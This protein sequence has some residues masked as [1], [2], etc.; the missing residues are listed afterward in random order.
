M[1]VAVRFWDHAEQS[2]SPLAFVVYGEVGEVTPEHV[3]ID[4][5]AYRD[6]HHRHDANEHRFVIVRSA[7][8][9]WDRLVPA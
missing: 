2:S 3:C 7:I 9:D 8:I 6:R 4:S 5:W 1:V